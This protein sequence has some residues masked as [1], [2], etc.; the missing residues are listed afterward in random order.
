[1]TEKK[2]TEASNDFYIEFKAEYQGEPKP[3][4]LHVKY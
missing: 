1:M 2:V 3:S 4:L